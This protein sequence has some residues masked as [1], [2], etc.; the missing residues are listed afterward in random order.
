MLFKEN[1][2]IE[3]ILENSSSYDDNIEY[4]TESKYSN[5]PNYIPIVENTRIGKYIVNFD[6]MVRFAEDS[7]INF[8][9][10]MKKI[11]KSN[12]INEKKMITSVKEST[13]LADVDI[14]NELSDIDFA[15]SPTPSSNIIYQFT[16]SC[17]DEFISSADTDFIDLLEGVINDKINSFEINNKLDKYNAKRDYRLSTGFKKLLKGAKFYTINTPKEKI[18]TAL[19]AINDKYQMLVRTLPKDKLNDNFWQKIL[20]NLDKL[21]KKFISFLAKK[22]DD[23]PTPQTKFK[24]LP[25]PQ[26]KVEALPTPQTK[27]NLNNDLIKL[28]MGRKDK[29]YQDTA[30]LYKKLGGRLDDIIS[31]NFSENDKKLIMSY[32]LKNKRLPRNVIKTV[33]TIANMK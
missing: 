22:D 19:S 11:A 3:T 25:T 14:I 18:A 13:I 23:T 5:N 12:K 6:D 29:D 20:R 31:K 10:A 9:D 28:D 1:N 26:T 24:A 17:L 7:G 2:N 15:I 27:F 32:L 16:E 8:A 4:L 21:I 33:K 30:D